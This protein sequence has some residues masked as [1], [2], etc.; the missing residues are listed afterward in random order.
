MLRF[1]I[2]LIVLF[3]TRISFSQNSFYDAFSFETTV[4]GDFIYNFSGGIKTGYTYIGMEDFAISFD[5]E[6]AKMWKNGNLFIHALNAHGIGPST[7]LTGD[8]QILSNIEAGD[9]TGL[10][11]LWYS[12]SFSNFTFLIGQHDLNSEFVGTKY[13]GTFIN[14][15]FGIAPNISL[16]VPVSV[17]PVA[18]PCILLKYEKEDKYSFKVA[19]YDGDPGNFE[20]NRFNL[21]WNINSHEGFLNIGEFEYFIHSE[22]LNIGSVKIGGYYHTGN[23][24]NY[25]DTLLNKKGNFGLYLISD[26]NIFPKSINAG[27]G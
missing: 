22:D 6:A 7:K 2:I 18:A 24:K 19:S 12:Q 11:E 20:N 21:Q 10:Y 27:R 25:S 9:Y 14:S 17:Y 3:G 1:L 26:Y 15:S 16:N 5:T 23:F 4:T 13:G 8:L